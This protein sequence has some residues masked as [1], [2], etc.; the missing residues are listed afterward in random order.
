MNVLKRDA[1]ERRK[2]V[3]HHGLGFSNEEE[4]SESTMER[5]EDRDA[6]GVLNQTALH[7]SKELPQWPQKC[8]VT[9]PVLTHTKIKTW[10]HYTLNSFI[11][12]HIWT[13]RSS[14]L[15]SLCFLAVGRWP[16][17]WA[18]PQ[19][20]TTGP[21][22]YFSHTRSVCWWWCNSPNTIEIMQISL[23]C[24]L[25]AMGTIKAASHHQMRYANAV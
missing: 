3:T 7:S 24:D 17:A 6:G 4:L 10:G 20:D 23:T 9:T 14:H 11:I 16:F 18:I 19:P 21:C 8:K 25:V 1:K 22:L 5:K 13:I 12:T 15:H 2:M